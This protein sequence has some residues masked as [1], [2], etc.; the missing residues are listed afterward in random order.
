MTTVKEKQKQKKEQQE[1]S[2]LDSIWDLMKT[3][4]ECMVVVF[5]IVNFVARPIR[6]EGSS[7]Y[8]T[9]HS[10]AL[11][12]AN[13][14]GKK[15]G[16]LERFDIAIIEVENRKYLVKRIIGL[17]GETI[18]YSN[19]VLEVDGKPIEEPFLDTDYRANKEGTF[20]EDVS[21]ITLGEGEYYCLG[22]NRPASRDSRY[23][24]PFQNDQIIAKGAFIFFPFDQFGVKS[25]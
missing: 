23:Y 14:Y 24:G 12:F 1:D 10:N 25:W 17:P 5:L 20:M 7:M 8:P 13:V 15:F 21:P 3:F 2:V 4:M 18:Q 22:D 11:G 9:L 6:V 19:G 16:K